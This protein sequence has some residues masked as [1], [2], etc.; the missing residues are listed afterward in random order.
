MTPL[1]IKIRFKFFTIRILFYC[2]IRQTTYKRLNKK[3]DNNI[4]RKLEKW[5]K[6]LKIIK[7]VA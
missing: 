4:H 6:L 3:K 1:M 7:S 5:S 2:R